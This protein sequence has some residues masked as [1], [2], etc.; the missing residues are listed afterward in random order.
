MPVGG[1]LQHQGST[2][3]WQTA[4]HENQHIAAPPSDGPAGGAFVSRLT[5]K[6]RG[7]IAVLR[8]WGP[9]A[10]DI[11]D[12][13]F[14]PIRGAR[15]ADTPRGR[16]RLGR[17]GDGLGDEVV[18]VVLQEEPPSVEVQCHG[19]EAAVSLVVGAL[20]EAGAGSYDGP[21]LA[22]QSSDDHFAQ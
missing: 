11:A 4:S 18:A 7:A 21:P 15:L 22:N 10:I 8:V 19:G 17:I 5:A 2:A 3:R 20:Q 6:G 1:S 14:R 13:V 12:A 16:L 9:R